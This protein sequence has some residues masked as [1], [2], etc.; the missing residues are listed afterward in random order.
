MPLSFQEKKTITC[1]NTDKL[2]KA[3]CK[4]KANYKK[5]EMICVEIC[6]AGSW[7]EGLVCAEQAFI[8]P[9]SY[10]PSPLCEI[11]RNNGMVK[12]L[13]IMYCCLLTMCN[14]TFATWEESSFELLSSVNFTRSFMTLLLPALCLKTVNFRGS[15]VGL[16]TECLLLLQS[17]GI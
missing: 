7:T 4:V 14:F 12:C 6:G 2:T 9:L 11:P 1:S 17:T 8:L 5:S 16:M 13:E 10:S 15:R 3:L